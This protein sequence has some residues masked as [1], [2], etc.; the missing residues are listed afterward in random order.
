MLICIKNKSLSRT[1]VKNGSII[2]IPII[3][4]KAARI[5]I[6]NNIDPLNKSDLGII[7]PKK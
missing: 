7:D 6:R 1:K 5:V 3:S 2:P 4:K